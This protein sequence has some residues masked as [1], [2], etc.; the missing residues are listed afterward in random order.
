MHSVSVERLLS[1]SVFEAAQILRS[2]RQ[3]NPEMTNEE[4]VETLRA[5]RADFFALDYEAG[6][7]L[8]SALP[9]LGEEASTHT[10]FRTCLD[11]IVAMHPPLWVR[12]AP[13]GREQVIRAVEANGLQC[14]RAAGLLEAPPSEF[15]RNW[16]DSLAAGVRADRD[17]ALLAQGR[18]AELWS[19]EREL[20]LLEDEG[21]SRKPVWAAI[22]DN[23]LGYDILSYRK[24]GV[25]EVSKL[26]EVKSSALSPP[27]LILTRKEWEAAMMYGEALEFHLWSTSSKELR[28][29]AVEEMRQH[30]P[31]NC[32]KGEWLNVELIFEH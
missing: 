9:P 30:I 32:G 23:S 26:I 17:A 18:E 24:I 2:F 8:E 15:T 3:L 21:I 27:R 13:G 28:I 22:E 7:I 12:L 20:T 31:K 6:L 1:M 10:F 11:T 14:F 16:W 4:I 19:F 5:V 25:A 29:I